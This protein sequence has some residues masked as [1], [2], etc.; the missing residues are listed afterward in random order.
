[1]AA[2][3]VAGIMALWLQANPSLTVADVR[4]L[5]AKTAIK[6]TFM[7]ETANNEYGMG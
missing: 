2:P 1:M 6:K 4:N 7:G 5:L 3:V